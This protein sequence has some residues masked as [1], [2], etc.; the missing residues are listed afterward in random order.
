MNSQ[1]VCKRLGESGCYFLSL[2]HLV[3]CDYAAIGLFRQAREAGIVDDEVYVS[4]P[5][6]LLS[7]AAGGA[8]SVRKEGPA[9]SP[10]R[11]ELLIRRYERKTTA[12]LMGHFVVV[13]GGKVWDPL[14]VSMTVREGQPVS[15][16]VVR[17][18]A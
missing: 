16:R 8:W 5:S 11:D 18:E 2:L 17:R 12:G 9:Y 7:L 10:A 3:G 13:E 1:V 4:N 14:D 15:S 6:A